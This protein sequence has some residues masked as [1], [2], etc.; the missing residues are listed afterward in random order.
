MILAIELRCCLNSK[1]ARLSRLVVASTL[2]TAVHMQLLGA[3]PM[4]SAVRT[5]DF[6]ES[7]AFSP[8]YLLLGVIC[9]RLA[10]VAFSKSL[11]W[12]EDQFD[13]LPGR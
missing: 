4:L 2:A 13:K 6:P 11:Y 12:V 5:M 8:F 3:G 7:P 10:A 1:R 9:G